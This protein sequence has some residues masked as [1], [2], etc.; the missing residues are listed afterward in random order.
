[1]RFGSIDVDGLSRSAFISLGEEVERRLFGVS[2]GLRR[3]DFYLDLI[4]RVHFIDLVLDDSFPL[5]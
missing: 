5:F 3:S 4:G 1:M 2:L